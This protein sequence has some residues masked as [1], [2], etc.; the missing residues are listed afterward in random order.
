MS[1]LVP[2]PTLGKYTKNHCTLYVV[3]VLSFTRD[4]MYCAFEDC[5]LVCWLY[6]L[7]GCETGVQ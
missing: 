7:Q 3:I 4:N 5:G 2:N 1:I 6:L